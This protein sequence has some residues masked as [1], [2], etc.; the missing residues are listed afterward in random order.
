VLISLIVHLIQA[1]VYGSVRSTR[2]G[3]QPHDMPYIVTYT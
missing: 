2:Q 1:V 3:A